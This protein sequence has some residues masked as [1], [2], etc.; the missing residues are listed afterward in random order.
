VLLSDTSSRKLG[1]SQVGWG[2]FKMT[3]APKAG[4]EPLVMTGRFTALAEQRNGK[5]VYVVDHASA[6]PPPPPKK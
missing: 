1:K 5:W 3:P 6:D 4:G 2:R